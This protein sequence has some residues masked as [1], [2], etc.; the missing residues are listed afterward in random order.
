MGMSFGIIAL[1][2]TCIFS[3]PTHSKKTARP[4]CFLELENYKVT[5]VSEDRI[6]V[7]IRDVIF[8]KIHTIQMGQ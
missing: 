7:V 6:A 4:S 5:K 2:S 3:L 8:Y 1:T